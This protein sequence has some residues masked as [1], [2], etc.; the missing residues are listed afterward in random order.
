MD[1]SA[2]TTMIKM[3]E[4]VPDQLQETVVEHMRDYIEYL[5]DEA[6]WKNSFSRNPG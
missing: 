1:T 2:A 4:T 3:L 6:K 5:L